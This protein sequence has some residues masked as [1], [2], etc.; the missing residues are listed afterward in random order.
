MTPT[1]TVGVE[2]PLQDDI[3]ALLRQSDDVAAR[4][5]P[6]EYR[7]P[8]TPD[9]L[10]KPGI[11]VVVAREGKS[12]LGICA[13]LE[14]DDGTIELK[15]MIVDVEARGRGVG[16]LLLHGAETEAKRLGVYA[17]RLEVGT[18]DIEAQS[19]YRTAGFVERGPF[20]PYQSTP[21][22]LFLEKCVLTMLSE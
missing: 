15:R 17:I 20:P 10:A 4:L 1:L 21:I 8:I 7:R 5:Y 14:G 13:L 2:T 9:V 3:A 11:R 18:R 6:G 16:R 22:C 19:L 12:L